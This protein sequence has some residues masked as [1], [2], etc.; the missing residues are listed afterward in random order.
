MSDAGEPQLQGAAVL[1]DGGGETAGFLVVSL[2]QSNLR[3][4]LEGTYGSQNDL[5]LFS[6][7]WRPVYC[8]QSALAE[9]LGPELRRRVLAGESLDGAAEGFCTA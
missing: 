2:Y 9:S 4:L 7:F 5:L 3:R 6:R 8:A 1:T